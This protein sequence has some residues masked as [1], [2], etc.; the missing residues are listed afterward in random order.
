MEKSVKKG[1][2]LCSSTKKKILF[3]STLQS[4]DRNEDVIKNDLKNTL[5]GIKKHARLVQ[6]L[7]CK[8]VYT[9]PR[10]NL[11]D[12]MSGY[13]SVEDPD[14]LRTKKYRM[15][16]ISKHVNKIK[17]HIK[18]GDLLDVGCFCG[19]FLDL[20][21]KK[22]FNVAGIE[23]SRWASEIVIKMGYPIYGS[24]L[25]DISNKKFDVI[26][27]WDVIEHLPDPLGEILKV[28]KNLKKN[29]IIAVS[30]PDIEN[31]LVKL[32]GDRHPFF[33][34]MHITLFTPKNLN[35]LLTIA[36]FEILE[37]YF[38]K[39]EYPI[40]YYLERLSE[41]LPAL[42]SIPK[43]LSTIKA[44]QKITISFLPNDEFTI[45]ARKV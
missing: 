8:V 45:I 32:L 43:R 44:F 15:S 34:R 21:S 13:E 36:G 30:T 4:K 24:T 6:C 2:P 40:S 31:F 25:D 17:G 3:K 16:L 23:P 38:Y 33:V 28:R 7:K 9:N 27:M 35:L 26:T 10:E 20:A 37:T 41:N 14:Y 1:C 11:Q 18:K 12:F 42:K 29:G 39:R 22:G 19:F 5:T